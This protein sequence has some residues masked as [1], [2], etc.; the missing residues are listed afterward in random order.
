MRS[1]TQQL[2]QPAPSRWLLVALATLAVVPA[3]NQD[4]PLPTSPAGIRVAPAVLGADFTDLGFDPVAI[5]G[6]GQVAGTLNGRAV[7][8]TPGGGTQDLGTLGGPSSRG[9]AI[10]ESGHV[11]GSSTTATG[12]THAFLWAPGQGMR[13]LGTLPGGESSI[14]RGINDRGEVVGQSTRPRV[15]PL[16]LRRPWTRAF[17]WTPALGMEDLGTLS[18][19]NGSIAYDINNGGQVVGRAYSVDR[20]ILPPT[21]PELFSRAFVWAPGQ[22]MQDIGALSG[23]FSI[24]HA[25]NDEGTVVGRSWVSR[26]TSFVYHAFRWTPA[27]G[28][29]DLGAFA[30][31]SDS[32]VA[33]G[34]NNSG[35]IVGSSKVGLGPWTA[36]HAFLWTTSEGLETLTPTTGIATAR[37][38]NNSLQVVGDGRVA[39]LNL[40]PGNVLPV[41]KAGGPYAGTEGSEVPFDMSGTDLDNGLIWG[42]VRYGDGTQDFFAVML[43]YP[44]PDGPGKHVY[45]DNGTYTLTLIVVDSRGGR[46]TA[47]APVAIANVAPTII[48]GSLTAPA[49]PVLLADGTASAPI[50][51]E[52]RDPAGNSDVYVAEIACGN[53]VV[54]TATDIRVSHPYGFTGTY[55][56]SCTYTSAGVYAVRATVADEDGGVSAPAFFRSVVVYDPDGASAMGSGFYAVTDQAK[57]KAAKAHFTF[58]AQYRSGQ[59]LPNGSA[60]F[61]VPGGQLDFESTTIEMLVASGT[62]AQFWGTGTLNGAAVRFRITAEDGPADRFRI[63]LWDAG[64]TSL[65]FDTQPGAAQDAPVTTAIEG[66]NIRVR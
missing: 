35:H 63:E 26:P 12:A 32:S 36:T 16:D 13:D 62:R 42:D 2:R 53:G 9:Y 30:M 29:Q 43:P 34:I 18:G 39:T 1:L 38:I 46:D 6:S 19:L 48:D 15:D 58:D 54:L 3:C 27:A 59:A 65:L 17:R 7:L 20:E 49:T 8:W 50:A 45:A 41:A 5:N 11:A 55:A 52:F 24:A 40:A 21:D 66:G 57:G 60:R 61:W 4:N 14:A 56:G 28:M 44:R 37:A 10:N 51:F 33:Y 22:G 23:G 47:T 64:G 25:I 31:S